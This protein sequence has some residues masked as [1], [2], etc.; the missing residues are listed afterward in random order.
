M[1]AR[2][3]HTPRRSITTRTL[4]PALALTLVFI[5]L[6]ACE[7]EQDE[8]VGSA[9]AL[10]PVAMTA[11]GPQPGPDRP[12]PRTENPFEDDMA[13]ILEGYRLFRWYNCEGCHG[14]HAGGG[15]GPSLRDA[16]WL[17]GGGGQ[18][19]FSS[20]YHG[21][22][23]GMPAWGTKLPPGQIWLLVS[24]IQ[25]LNTNYE[26]SAPPPNPSYPDAPHR[27]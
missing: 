17:Y 19:I 9:S 15:M 8:G 13:S 5:A 4:A 11:V 22:S 18:E 14:S 1:R 3:R 12:L 26:P 24:Y 7:E 10:P 21:R 23:N 16:D 25:S 2:I 6:A 27:Q 20:I